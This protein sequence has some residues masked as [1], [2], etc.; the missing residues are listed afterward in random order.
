[1][2]LPRFSPKRLKAL[3][4]GTYRQQFGKTRK[5]TGEINTLDRLIKERGAFSEISGER[6]VGKDHPRYHW[7]VF[8]ILGKGE[9]PDYRL[10]PENILLT[11]W[12][13]QEAW[14]QRKWTLKNNPTWAHVFAKEA[15]L[16]LAARGVK[17]TD[18]NV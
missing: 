3:E 4:E 6:L 15:A 16:K 18:T 8:H 12:Q 13:E 11:T 2:S 5:P 9:Y 14:T 1:M 10:D 17:Q 7:Q